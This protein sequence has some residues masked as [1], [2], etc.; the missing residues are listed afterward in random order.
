MAGLRNM[1]YTTCRTRR[2]SL[3]GH[4]YGDANS[5]REVLLG[6]IRARMA[7]RYLSYEATESRAD[8]ASV[9]IAFLAYHQ[10]ISFTSRLLEALVCR[11]P[12]SCRIVKK[13]RWRL[14]L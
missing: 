8:S 6:S 11:Q 7:V 13:L 2:K 1:S 12:F 14:F 10:G 4:H 5:P 9:R 3:D